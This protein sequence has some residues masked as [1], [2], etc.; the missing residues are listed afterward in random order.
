ME[1][2]FRKFNSI[3][4]YCILDIHTRAVRGIVG[5]VEKNAKA[6]SLHERR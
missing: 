2:S 4:Y 3:Y 5:F 1:S 6:Y